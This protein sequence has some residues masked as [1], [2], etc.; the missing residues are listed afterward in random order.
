[1]FFKYFLSEFFADTGLENSPARSSENI[2][3][4]KVALC[5]P[6]SEQKTPNTQIRLIG[7]P[8]FKFTSVVEAP[9]PSHQEVEIGGADNNIRS[10]Q[11]DEEEAWIRFKIG[12]EAY[13]RL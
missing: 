1:M 6:P 5:A 4:I 9:F 7:A 8:P 3:S 10:L 12:R 13:G 2:P 11:P